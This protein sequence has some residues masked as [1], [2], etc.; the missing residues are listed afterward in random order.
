[1]SVAGDVQ[2]PACMKC[3]SDDIYTRYH[4]RG[5]EK[6]ACSCS[7]CDYSSLSRRHDEHLHRM[8]R[9]CGFDWIAEVLA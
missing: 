6:E 5:C 1:V 8:C 4:A 3:G 2:T 7:R 9:G